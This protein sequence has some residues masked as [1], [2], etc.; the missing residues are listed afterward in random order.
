MALVE[1]IEQS[2]FSAHT[3][4]MDEDDS[5]PD[6]PPNQ[7]DDQGMLQPMTLICRH[8]GHH[9]DQ[10]SGAP[11]PDKCEKCGMDGFVT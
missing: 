9:Q 8:C 1:Q 7:I 5:K 10:A 2:I 3:L 4:R 11:Y 6:G